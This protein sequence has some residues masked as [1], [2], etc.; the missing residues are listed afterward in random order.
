MV[1]VNNANVGRGENVEEGGSS[2]GRTG[3]GKKVASRVMAPESFISVKEAANFEEWTRKRRKIALGHRVDLFDMEGIEII[4]NLFNDIGWGPLLTVDEL[5]FPEMIYELYANLHKGRI[6]MHKNITH[7]YVTSRIAYTY[8]RLLHHMISNIIIPNVG[9]KSSIT[10]LHSFVILALHEHRIMNFGYMAIV[11]ILATQTSSTKCL[12]YDC[13]LTKVFQYFVLNLIGV[14][15]P[16]GAG[17]IYNKHTLKRM[18]F[19]KNEEGMLGRGG[20]DDDEESDKDDEGNEGQ[21]AMNI[22]E[23][24]SEIEFEEETYR[25]EMMQKKR[26]ERVEEDVRFLGFQNENRSSYFKISHPT[27]QKSSDFLF[28]KNIGCPIL[29][30]GRQVFTFTVKK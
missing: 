30:T 6:Q 4:L 19:E 25:R 28:I 3:K 21:E 29:K 13:F 8:G 11:H 2:R 24:E 16:I 23:E 15:D 22:D 17:K 9:H 26:Q 18:G 10:N 5:F 27:F 20:Q 7:Q 14:G 12:P 1:K